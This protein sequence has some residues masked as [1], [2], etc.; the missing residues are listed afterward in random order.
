MSINYWKKLC[1][2][3]QLFSKNS[4][5]HSND[6]L[7]LRLLLFCICTVHLL[8]YLFFFPEN[9]FIASLFH[10][11]K[12]LSNI[13]PYFYQNLLKKKKTRIEFSSSL[14][15]D[16]STLL[17]KRKTSMNVVSLSRLSMYHRVSFLFRLL[18]NVIC[19]LRLYVYRSY[20]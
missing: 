12:T 18:F 6:F 15:N 13:H 16:H 19:T 9:V 17:I 20:R 8:P 14:Q 4:R 11:F 10:F 2:M 1:F 3:I 5:F 7:R